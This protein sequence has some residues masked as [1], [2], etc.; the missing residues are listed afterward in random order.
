MMLTLVRP[1]ELREARWSEGDTQAGQWI[2]PAERMKTSVRHNVPLSSQ[3]RF[4]FDL[5]Q[6]MGQPAPQ[7]CGLVDQR[8]DEST[9]ARSLVSMDSPTQ[10]SALG[11]V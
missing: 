11:V 9:G 7:Q 8:Q 4:L 2:I 6:L 10:T 1:S 5:Q 3:A